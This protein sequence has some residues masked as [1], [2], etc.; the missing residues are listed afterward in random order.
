MVSEQ[1]VSEVKQVFS[2]WLLG[3][4]YFYLELSVHYCTSCDTE[5]SKK[6]DVKKS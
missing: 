2:F 4:K 3:Q 5:D 6:L 1:L